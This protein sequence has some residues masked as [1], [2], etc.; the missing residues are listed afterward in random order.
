M[1]KIDDKLIRSWCSNVDSGKDSS[2]KL[3]EA[4]TEKAFEPCNGAETRAES[5]IE[6]AT[7]S[8]IDM[9][10]FRAL[11]DGT[12]DDYVQERVRKSSSTAE[13]PV[14]TAALE[15]VPPVL[16]P[17]KRS[18]ID[19]LLDRFKGDTLVSAY[20]DDLALAVSGSKKEVIETDM[21]EEV[22]KVAGWS[23]EYGLTLNIGKCEACLF[24]PQYCG[25]QV[26]ANPHHSR[27]DH[28]RNPAPEVSWNHLWQDADLQQAHRRSHQQNEVKNVSP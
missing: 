20:T 24:T 22:D 19:D 28:P 25:V 18:S 4:A 10:A 12:Y 14:T 8:T 9:K 2:A 7:L 15:T 3:L 16:P 23:K 11:M 5:C 21:Q 1:K 27:T 17:L 26:E 13:S 6:E